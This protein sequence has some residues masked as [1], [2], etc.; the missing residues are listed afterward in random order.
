MLEFG[1]EFSGE[2]S[3]YMGSVSN[4]VSLPCQS[5]TPAQK[6]SLLL[7]PSIGTRG[8]RR[9]VVWS[10]CTEGGTPLGDAYTDA[11]LSAIAGGDS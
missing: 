3:S 5:L 6:T 8:S 1:D 10:V 11:T 9:L 7:A 4:Q 2:I